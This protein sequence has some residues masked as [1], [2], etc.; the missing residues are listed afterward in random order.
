VEEKK[1]KN[2]NISTFELRRWVCVRYRDI[3]TKFYKDWLSN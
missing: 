2:K 3:H 1:N